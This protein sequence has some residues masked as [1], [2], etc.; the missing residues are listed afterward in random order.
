MKFTAALLQIAPLGNDQRTFTSQHRRVDRGVL[1]SAAVALCA[2]LPIRGRIRAKGRRSGR[3]S[4]CT[5]GVFC[6]QRERR[7]D[8][9][10]AAGDG[11]SN[12]VPFPR[13][14]LLLGD[15][16]TLLRKRKLCPKKLCH[17]RGSPHRFAPKLRPS[18]R[19]SDFA[20]GEFRA[21][22]PMQERDLQCRGPTKQSRAG[23]PLE[24]A[25]SAKGWSAPP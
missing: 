12:A 25:S 14:L 8:F 21:Q 20:D 1:Q 23:P 6:E 9:E 5:D 13:P 15:A 17:L 16:R 18:P 4:G 7:K 3:I 2:G 10:R 24:M 19:T 11:D 22:V